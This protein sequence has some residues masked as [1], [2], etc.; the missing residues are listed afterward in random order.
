MKKTLVIIGNVVFYAVILCLL[1]FSIANI[2]VK[3]EDQ[4]PTMFGKGFVSV[5]TDSMNG[6]KD[7]S[8]K[9]GALVIVD[10]L[11]QEDVSNLEIGDIVVFYDTLQ[12]TDNQKGFIIHRVVKNDKELG[13]IYTQG[14]KIAESNPFKGDGTDL[15]NHYEQLQYAQVKA[16]YITHVASI[17]AVITYLRTPVGFGVGI[18]LPL[19]IFLIVEVI[20]LVRYLLARNKEKLVSK[21]EEEKARI[22]QEILEQLLKEQEDQ[23]NK[24]IK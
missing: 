8:F 5:L 23:D 3:R 19:L 17:G 6:G 20:I 14:D 18:L 22:R 16:T 7:S 13:Y 2:T 12:G 15:L 9:E 24:K 4:F 21:V 10:T 11:S 1:L